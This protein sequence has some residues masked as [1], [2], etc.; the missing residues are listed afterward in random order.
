MGSFPLDSLPPSL[1]LV[2]LPFPLSLPGHSSSATPLSW[3]SPGRG[4]KEGTNG[5][6]V[7]PGIT[8]QELHPGP[9]ISTLSEKQGK[10]VN[11]I[12]TI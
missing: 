4:K 9:W 12:W 10:P 11:L 5:M 7:G 2:F 1:F 6:E 8:I 3:G